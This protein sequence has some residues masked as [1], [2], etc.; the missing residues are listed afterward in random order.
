MNDKERDGR[1]KTGIAGLDNVLHGGLIANRLYLLDGNPGAGKTTLALQFLLEGI[2]HGE[3]CLYV[4]LSETRAELVAGAQSH[5]WSLDSLEIAE[6]AGDDEEL[7]VDSQ[8]TLYHPSEVELTE[9]T[10]RVLDIVERANP[11]RMVFDSLSEL[12]LLAQGSLR[13]RRQILALKQFFSRRKCTVLLVD[14][15]TSEGPDMQLHSIAHGVVS[16]DQHAPAYGSIARQLQVIKFRGSDFRSGYHDF[17]ILPGGLEVYPRLASGEHGVVFERA[18]VAS[19]VVALDQ[20]LGGG[21]DRGTC[22]LVSGTPGTG[23]STLTLQYAAAAA[24]RGDHAAIFAFDEA[25]ALLLHRAAALGIAVREGTG[26]G[27]VRIRQ[28]DPA[29]ITPGE[30]AHIV[31]RCVER[32]RARVVVIDSLNGYLN[33]MP[34]ASFLTAQLHELLA[35]LN[36]QGVATFLV[37]AQRGFALKDGDSVID[38][39][40]L[41]DTVITLRMFEHSGAVRKAISVLKKRSGP[42]ED[43]IRR[44]WFDSTG[45]HLGPPLMQLR[46]ILTGVPVE[47]GEPGVSDAFLAEHARGD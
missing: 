40:Y 41:A 47:S 13:Y 45:V 39:S 16:L 26:A 21:I 20:L 10:R 25:P 28:V 2:R 33:A 46:G 14:D 29:D 12:R 6:L 38:S 15:R 9:T 8:L 1:C 17:R 5:G 27:E 23:K 35:Y 34:Q 44:I 3:R 4:T 32:D 42:H 37:L 22:T 11:D 7:N 19:G 24:Q 36:G 43:S 30:F 31:R 18:S